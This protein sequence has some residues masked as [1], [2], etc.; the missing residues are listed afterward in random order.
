MNTIG[1]VL[2]S[3][4]YWLLCLSQ[5]FYT[6]PAKQTF[7]ASPGYDLALRATDADDLRSL[8]KGF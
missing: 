7:Y 2:A 3:V 6:D 4:G 5:R 1:N 8:L